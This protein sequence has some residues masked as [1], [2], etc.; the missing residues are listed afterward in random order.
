MLERPKQQIISLW[1]LQG[2]QR[3]A[4][5]FIIQSGTA[6]KKKR[7]WRYAE[8]QEGAD[9]DVDTYLHTYCFSL[10]EPSI[11]T[12]KVSAVEDGIDIN[13]SMS[14][15]WQNSTTR[16]IRNNPRYVLVHVHTLTPSTPVDADDN[17]VLGDGRG[18]RGGREVRYGIRCRRDCNASKIISC[19]IIH[20]LLSLSLPPSVS[21]A[22]A[23]KVRCG[24]AEA[25]C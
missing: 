20:R 13:E 10:R 1:T 6:V 8:E 17:C 11:T 14:R 23:Q 2:G 15:H 22:M 4:R 12:T 9:E 25:E 24:L 21:Y 7:L 5:A 19:Q 18:R 16:Q 3:L